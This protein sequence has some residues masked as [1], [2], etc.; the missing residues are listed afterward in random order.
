MKTVIFFV[1]AYGCGKT[2]IV[3]RLGKQYGNKAVCQLEDEATLFFLKSKDK[4][5]AEHFYLFSMYYRLK[6][7][8]DILIKL[9]YDYAF[10]DGHPLSNLVYGRTFFE[11]DDGHT[12]NFYEMSQCAKMH[13]RMHQYCKRN[14][15][16]EDLVGNQ[17]RQILVY[18]DLPFEENRELILNR[19]RNE[20]YIAGEVDIDYL[21]TV[22][23]IYQSEIF[24]LAR[25]YDIPKVI[26]LKSKEELESFDPKDL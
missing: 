7:T 14:G 13:A 8:L 1:G 12:F 20:R 24:H 26:T 2:Y 6:E 17:L 3:D 21:L 18:I 15:M 16:Y 23:R 25:Y 19:N 11:L 9:N 10:I 4:Y 5:M 22:R